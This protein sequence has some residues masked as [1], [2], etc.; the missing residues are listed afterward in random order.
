[1]QIKFRTQKEISIGGRV[2]LI[3]DNS[4]WET[5]KLFFP[6]LFQKGC[7]LWVGG[8][9]EGSAQGV[10][11]Q[12]IAGSPPCT[13]YC[14]EDVSIPEVPVLPAHPPC[15][16]VPAA[17]GGGG[18]AVT[19]LL[20][21]Q[22]ETGFLGGRGG[23]PSCQASGQDHTWLQGALLI[24]LLSSHSAR[25]MSA[26][27]SA[28]A[29]AEAGPGVCVVTWLRRSLTWQARWRRPRWHGCEGEERRSPSRW[30]GGRGDDGLLYVSSIGRWVCA[31]SDGGRI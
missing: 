26:A 4:I 15:V 9:E 13:Q 27:H 22:A 7:M 10:K 19:G 16:C 18:G 20:G 12:Q 31:G 8:T 28:Q 17:G 30:G 6:L 11:V 1:M 23:H 14:Y 2:I 3:L 24:S 29:A 25:V 5:P 21:S